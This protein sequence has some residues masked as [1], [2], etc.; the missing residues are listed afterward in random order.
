MSENLNIINSKDKNFYL[1]ILKNEPNNYDAI[2]KLGLIEVKES[3]FNSAKEKFK[4]LIKIDINKFEG[5]LNLSNIY[6]LE[7]Q[8]TKANNILNNYLDEINENIEIIN[9]LSI[10]LLN[11][12][13]YQKL[14]RLIDNYIYKYE[15]YILY[16]LKGYIL[17]KNDKISKS[18]IYFKKSITINPNFWQ[19]Y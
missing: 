1:R 16:Y 14:E 6:I 12:K 15:S 8:V 9:A 3:D 5:H 2:L 10:N 7:N 11:S 19:S 17:K 4:K 18:E 13:D